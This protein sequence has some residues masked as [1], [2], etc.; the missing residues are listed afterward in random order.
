MVAMVMERNEGLERCLEGRIGDAGR[1]ER[2][3]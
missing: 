2:Q 3:S 1:R